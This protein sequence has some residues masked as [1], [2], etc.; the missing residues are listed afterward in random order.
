MAGMVV[1]KGIHNHILVQAEIQQAGLQQN[2][3]KMEGQKTQVFQIQ[4]QGVRT[5]N[6]VSQTQTQVFQIQTQKVFSCLLE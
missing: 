4:T 5:Q 2:H 1:G 6:Q 3:L